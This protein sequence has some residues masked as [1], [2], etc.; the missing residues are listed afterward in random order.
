MSDTVK[1]GMI[2]G[3]LTPSPAVDE[4][5]GWL[6]CEVKLDTTTKG[7]AVPTLAHMAQ[8][9]LI[10]KGFARIV[11]TTNLD[12]LYSKA[13][14]KAHEEVCF[15]HGD[16]FTERCT[17][18]GYDF[19]R[20]FHVRNKGLNVHDHHVGTCS[21]CGSKA[22]ASYTGASGQRIGVQDLNV[23]TK[24]THINFDE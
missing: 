14:L 16:T 18:C 9:T 12:G 7:H 24:D 22:P 4:G 19:E 3:A 21:R 5:D 8:A 15:L 13:G 2:W 20:N 1:M 10:R 6:R 23:G 11:V 17:N